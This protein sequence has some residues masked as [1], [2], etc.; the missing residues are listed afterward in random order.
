[1]SHCSIGRL[2]RVLLIYIFYEFLFNVILLLIPLK[3]TGKTTNV[4]P[5]DK[6][7]KGVEGI[8]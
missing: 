6:R 3:N 8:S 2:H 1:M 7:M 4:M 5:S